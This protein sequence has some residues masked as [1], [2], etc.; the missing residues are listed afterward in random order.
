VFAF[1]PGKEEVLMRKASNV[2]EGIMSGVERSRRGLIILEEEGERAYSPRELAKQAL[3]AAEG[4]AQ[5]GVKPGDRVGIIAQTTAHTVLTLLGCWAAG[6]VAVPLPLPMRA[7]DPASFME[8]SRRRLEKVG[9]E[10]LALPGAFLPL[11]SGLEEG[12][13]LVAMEELP[14]GVEASPVPRGKREVA[15]VQFT[16]GSTSDPRGVILTHGNILANACAIA[17]KVG[18]GPRDTVVSWMPLYHD[19][20]LIGF[21]ITALGAGCSLVL[22]SP[23]RFVADP[24]L[25]MRACGEYRATITGGPNFAYALSTR[26]MRSGGLGGTDLSS[27]R[28]AL[29]GAEPIDPQVLDEL[30]EAG[31]EYGLQPE[32]PYPVYGLA[33]ATLAVTFPEPGK[34]YQKDHVSRRGI[35]E[36]GE[37]L[38]CAPDGPDAR[39][40]V[41]LGRPLRG[42]EVRIVRGDGTPAGEREVGEVCVRGP[43]LMQGYWGDAAATA[44]ALRGGW[45]HTGDLGYLADGNLFLVGRIKDMVIIGGRN[46]FP[47]DVERCAERVEG[48]RKGNAVAFG[49]T[50][51]RGRERLV[52]VGETRLSCPQAA[53]ETARAVSSLVREEIG[54]PVR[55]VVLVP[56]G[57]LPKTSSGKKRR[58]L[59]RELYLNQ[60][61]QAIAR[62]GAPVMA[63]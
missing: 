63:N 22:M 54:V 24:S 11:V 17:E 31:A 28:L 39:C 62:S 13:R 33:E 3:R 51:R 7:V 36:R 61:L 44:E 37:A 26:V 40:L 21:L 30:V 48:M 14:A 58:F 9:A 53:L 47:E 12:F 59:C 19:M 16:S 6:A 46:L 23:Q 38:P 45:L 32:V 60:K 20:G 50:T 43:S 49:V 52:L 10:V 2:W 18:A 1:P 29:N 35:E 57:T 41:S 34:I 15:L 4:L 42:L 56:A 55:E 5:L 27:L 8:Q 25:W